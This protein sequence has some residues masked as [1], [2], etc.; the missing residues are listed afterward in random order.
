MPTDDNN[1]VCVFPLTCAQLAILTPAVHFLDRLNE[2]FLFLSE[3]GEY[4]RRF[5]GFPT[6]F[7]LFLTAPGGQPPKGAFANCFIQIDDVSER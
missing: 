3:G 1:E 2:Q 7:R 6:V 4:E 5:T